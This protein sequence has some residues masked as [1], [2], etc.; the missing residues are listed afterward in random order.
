MRGSQSP[1]NGC[2]QVLKGILAPSLTLF[3][4][5][6]RKKTAEGPRLLAA[7]AQRAISPMQIS[8]VRC[9]RVA[10]SRT[11]QRWRKGSGR[12]RRAPLT[13]SRVTQDRESETNQPFTLGRGKGKR[14]DRHEIHVTQKRKGPATMRPPHHVAGLEL[15]TQ[16]A[17]Q[18]RQKGEHVGVERVALHLR[19]CGDA[20]QARTH[21]E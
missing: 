12:R 7:S 16:R 18:L 10:S 20:K 5:M 17:A 2:G 11:P 4:S 3:P 15:Q 9:S 6:K 21:R 1:E 19:V 13:T 14:K 8:L